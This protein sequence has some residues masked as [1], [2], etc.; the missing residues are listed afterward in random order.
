MKDKTFL[1][2]DYEGT[3]EKGSQSGLACVPTAAN[4]AANTP[5]GGINPV[6]ANLLASGKAWPTPTDPSVDCYDNGGTNASV[7]TPFSNRVD[8]AIVKLDQNIGKNN[9]LDRPLLLR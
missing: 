3:R 1:F 4:I 6:I 7:A 2:V 5:V 8:S 9:L